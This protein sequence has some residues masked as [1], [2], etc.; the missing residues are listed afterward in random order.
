MKAVKTYV[1]VT[2]LEDFPFFEFKE[3][4][5]L[6]FGPIYSRKISKEFMSSMKVFNE[7]IEN[8]IK[9]VEAV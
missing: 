6:K 1:F 7:I 9:V 2:R 8:M 4:L 5:L 3:L